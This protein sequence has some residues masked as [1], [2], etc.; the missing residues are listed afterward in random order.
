MLQKNT[1]LEIVAKC[2]SFFQTKLV[3]FGRW[4]VFSC[5]VWEKKQN[6]T[7]RFVNKSLKMHLKNGIKCNGTWRLLYVLLDPWSCGN[8]TTDTTMAS[9][10]HLKR[11]LVLWKYYYRYDHGVFC[12]PYLIPGLMV[13]L[14]EIRPW[15]LLYVLRGSWSYGNIT[16]DKTMA[17]FVCPT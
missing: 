13:I 6:R 5:H 12:M 15:R 7:L 17:S 9:F 14:L 10:V 16:R 4:V 11:F 2:D 3:S 8:I 1:C